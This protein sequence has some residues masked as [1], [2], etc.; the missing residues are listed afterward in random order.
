M[1]ISP[2]IDSLSVSVCIDIAGPQVMSFHYSVDD[3]P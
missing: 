3:M 1:G 2:L